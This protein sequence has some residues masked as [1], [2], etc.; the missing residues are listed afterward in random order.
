MTTFPPPG[1]Y[2]RPEPSLYWMP[3]SALS[4]VPL[5]ALSASP[6]DRS[7]SAWPES[8]RPFSPSGGILGSF[9]EPNDAWDADTS[10]SATPSRVGGGLLASLS[11]QVDE[12]A[13]DPWPKMKGPA[14][15][16][17]TPNPSAAPRTFPSTPTIP[18]PQPFEFPPSPPVQYL[19]SAKYWGT[20][21][22]PS[23][24]ESLAGGLY[25]S[26]VPQAPRWDQIPTDST[27]SAAQIFQ[28][29]PSPTSWSAPAS[30]YVPSAPDKEPN[31]LRLA[32]MANSI[33][34]ILPL[35][36]VPFPGPP[37]WTSLHPGRARPDPRV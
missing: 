6:W 17:P 3:S 36:P 20:A 33:P 10:S 24:S 22:T 30:M 29:P 12:P 18:A 4:T 9:P 16:V 21:Q 23:S 14:W 34:G 19:D 32:G 28:E 25:L 11:Q 5:P 27:S 26:P 13:N 1:W 8:A 35:P 15:D 31:R 37:D 2:L 7:P